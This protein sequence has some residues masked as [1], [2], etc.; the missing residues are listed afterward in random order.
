MLFR[1]SFRSLCTRTCYG[2]HADTSWRM[3]GA[4]RAPCSTTSGTRTS[5]T[6]YATPS[7]L[8][9][10]SRIFGKTEGH[11]DL[12]DERYRKRFR[13]DCRISA[14]AQIA[15]CAIRACSPNR[16][17][18]RT[19]ARRE[20][21]AVLMVKRSDGSLGEPDGRRSEAPCQ[22]FAA[23]RRRLEF[24]IVIARAHP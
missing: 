17:L 14:S 22:G 2:T 20:L 13:R 10:G 12:S 8:R 15:S 7:S 24:S 23:A 5:C 3:M 4:T 9:N 19:H 18:G 6:P 21:D 16:T 1:S 11:K